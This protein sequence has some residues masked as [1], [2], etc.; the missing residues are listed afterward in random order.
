MKHFKSKHDES[1]NLPNLGGEE[2]IPPRREKEIK[3]PATL[4]PGVE[5]D[6]DE[7]I[8]TSEVYNEPVKDW[9]ELLNELGYDSDLYEIVEPVKVSCWDAPAGEGSTKRLYSYKAGIRAKR[10]TQYRDDDYSDLVTLIRKHRPLSDRLLDGDATFVVCLS[11]WQLGKALRDDTPILTT[12]GWKPHGELGIGDYVYS[13]NGAPVAVVGN[14]GSS[15]QDIYKVTWDDGEE[16]EATANHQWDGYRRF[17][18]KGKY[19][20][21]EVSMTTRELFEINKF[22]TNAS[23]ARPFHIKNTSP[24]EVSPQELPVDPYLFGAWLGDGSSYSG[25]ITSAGSDSSYWL[26]L[27]DCHTVKNGANRGEMVEI[28]IDGLTSKLNKMGVLGSKSIPKEYLDGSI[29]QR[30]SL[31][32]GLMDTDGYCSEDGSAEFCQVNNNI[33]DGME[34]LLNSLGMK[35]K[36]RVKQTTHQP[37]NILQFTPNRELPWQR[38]FRMQRKLDRLRY[39]EGQWTYSYIRNVEKMERASAQCITVEGGLYLAGVS[40]KATHNSDGD[41][42]EGTIKRILVMIDEVTDRIRELRK[43]GRKMKTLVVAGIGDMVENC[44]G[45]YASQ[46][47]TVELNRRQQIR[48]LRRLLTKAITTWSKLFSEVIVIA[49]PGNH[50]ENRNAAGKAFTTRG[51]NDDVS[52]FE[53]VAEILSANPDAYGHV[54]FI[55]PEDEISITIEVSGFI[56]GFAHGHVTSSGADPQKKIKEWWKNQKFTNNPIGD[57]NILITG[58]YHHFSVI[59]HDND[60]IHMQCPAMDGGSEWFNDLTGVDSRPGTLTFLLDSSD[61]PY[62][63]LEII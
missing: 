54:R 63:D 37:A 58:H 36:R 56:L 34:F 47:F 60:K 41:G 7:V 43:S 16:I 46:T 17:N 21:Y 8:V 45:H 11:D 42:T 53:M 13:P 39:G 6:G 33:A 35:V 18:R 5:W 14:T 61:K 31:V 38:V 62:R 55:L 24:L 10:F 15:V 1:L 27:F 29:D 49:V 20:R 59:E 50:G 23:Y 52:V 40:L 25:R 28:R 48:V 2:H 30:L 51:D 4:K 9:D 22:G 44:A 19:D 26:N 12:K 3:P 57:A 32:Q